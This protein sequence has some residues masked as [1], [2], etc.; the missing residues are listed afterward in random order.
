MAKTDWKTIGSIGGYPH[1]RIEVRAM[2]KAL[3]IIGFLLGYGATWL[4]GPHPP[5][6]T[7][8]PVKR[9]QITDSR[10]YRAPPVI[11]PVDRQ[12][13]PWP[14]IDEMRKSW[15]GLPDPPK[16]IPECDAIWESW[17]NYWSECYL[18]IDCWLDYPEPPVPNCPEPA[19]FIAPCEASPGPCYLD[20]P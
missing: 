6:T 13:E 12:W 3:I 4:V 16:V 19:A 8:S 1:M 9:D 7:G 17:W 15:V 10:V 5:A 2:K 18:G 14:S 20:R 11:R